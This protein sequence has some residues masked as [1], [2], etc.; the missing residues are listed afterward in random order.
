MEERVAGLYM[1]VE[2]FAM[3]AAV[4][5]SVYEKT[6]CRLSEVRPGTQLLV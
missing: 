4:M 6:A 5:A 2:V 1:Q 3:S